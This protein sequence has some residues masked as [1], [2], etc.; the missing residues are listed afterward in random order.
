MKKYHIKPGDKY[1]RL[2]CI[3]FD[4][5]GNHN[6]SYFLFKCDCGNEKIILGSSVKSG[7]TKSCGCYSMEV[8]QNK[9]LPENRGVIYQIILGYKHGAK[10]R[11][12]KWDL[13]IDQVVG[14]I[15]K[16]CYYC[17]NEKSNTKITKNYKEGYSYNGIDRLDNTKGYSIENCVPCCKQCNRAKGTMSFDEFIKWIKAMANQWG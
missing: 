14:I 12:Y 7:N 6:R 8:K 16:P 15:Q 1:G 2:T 10:E 11:G 13:I 4:H 3:R 9:R 17:G 5:I